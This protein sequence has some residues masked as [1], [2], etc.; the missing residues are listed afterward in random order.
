M[1]ETKKR[2]DTFPYLLVLPALL[3]VCFVYFYP[4]TKG[5]FLSFTSAKFVERA[6]FVGLQNYLYMLNDPG[7]WHACKITFFYSL[8]Y[9][10]GVFALGLGT[11]LLLNNRFKGRPLART[12]IILPYAIPD[13]AAVAV[14][15]WLFDYQYGVINFILKNLGIISEPVQWLANPNIALFSVLL[16]SVWRLFPFHSLAILSALQGVPEELYEAV[17][18]DG[19]TG[20]KKFWHITLPSISNIMGV[21]FLITIIWSF[22]R[23][24]II[25]ALTQGGPSQATETLVVQ[26]YLKAFK[27]YSMGYAG[28]IGTVTILFLMA[29]TVLY[30]IFSNK[31]NA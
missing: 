18:I 22:Q 15:T 9:L 2:F 5:L 8:F 6:P 1:N 17:E 20:I 30:F 12:L 29:V 25:W 23:F 28:A 4:I 26:I 7:F 13:I 10:I 21:L 11:A 3:I 24:T 27:Y 31:K 16:V 19:A 14:W